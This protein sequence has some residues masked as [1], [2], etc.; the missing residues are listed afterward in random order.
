MCRLSSFCSPQDSSVERTCTSE[1]GMATFFEMFDHLI[2]FIV[3]FSF[4]FMRVRS[5]PFVFISRTEEWP[6]SSLK[7]FRVISHVFGIRN[8][9]CWISIFCPISVVEHRHEWNYSLNFFWIYLWSLQIYLNL[10]ENAN[11]CESWEIFFHSNSI[12][13]P[14]FPENTAYSFDCWSSVIWLF[15]FSFASQWGYI[16]PRH[17]TESELTCTFAFA[18]LIAWSWH[19]VA[20]I[21]SE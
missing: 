21:Q 3:P 10:S 17:E 15:H 5:I 20:V 13:S 8:A 11:R 6:M 12:G 2:G 14:L 7:P 19:R 9:V 18:H 4:W 1:Y 16:F